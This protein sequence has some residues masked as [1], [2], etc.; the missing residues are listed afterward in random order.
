MALEYV[1]HDKAYVSLVSATS[2]LVLTGPAHNVGQYRDYTGITITWAA[3]GMDITLNVPAAD[4]ADGPQHAMLI[5]DNGN[6]AESTIYITHLV[7]KDA[8]GQIAAYVERN[9]VSGIEITHITHV[10][11]DGSDGQPVSARI[12]GPNSESFGTSE[13]FRV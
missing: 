3:S 2:R 12:S 4:A 11:S 13:A 9:R 6:E 8:V 7:H 1:C 10:G 5:L